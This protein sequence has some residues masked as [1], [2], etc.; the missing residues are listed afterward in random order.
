LNY[1]L[2][3]ELLRSLD[4]GFVGRLT[5][6]GR[7]GSLHLMVTSGEL[8]G[9]ESSEDD[10]LLLRRGVISGML[11][12]VQAG[13]MMRKV[14]QLPVADQLYDVL[15]EDIVAGL[16]F[17]RFKENI[18]SWLCA[19]SPIEHEA[20]PAIILTN[21]HLNHDS[22]A[23]VGEIELVLARTRALRRA[24]ALRTIV[25]HTG[26]KVEG[27][28]DKRL[29]S[30]VGGGRPLADIVRA[31]PFEELFTLDRVAQL[32]SDDV[33]AW[34]SQDTFIDDDVTEIHSPIPE[35]VAQATQAPPAPAHPPVEPTPA[36]L[37]SLRT[38]PPPP[39]DDEEGDDLSGVEDD[40]SELTLDPDLPSG[41]EL[42]L[43]PELE[44]E[45]FS[46]ADLGVEP[47]LDSP[48][49]PA[50]LSVQGFYQGP[51]QDIADAELAMFSDQ[52]LT[53]GKNEYVN[54]SELNQ[55]DYIE[56][57]T[58]IPEDDSLEAGDAGDGDVH[59]G[60]ARVRFSGPMLSDADARQKIEALNHALRVLSLAF[61]VG[62]GMG[63]G[64]SRIQLLLDGSPNELGMLFQKLEANDDGSISAT[65]LLAHLYRRPP[66]EHR[67]LLNR[68]LNDLME[69]ALSVGSEEMGD[70]AMDDVY[71]AYAEFK[72]AGSL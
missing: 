4:E 47:S 38:I 44:P 20:M 6:T 42:P 59:V 18:G 37:H 21:V 31:S 55:E 69:R 63:Y 24:E 57:P 51:D 10:I 19:E 35:P 13:E 32:L 28:E 60:N 36:P 72:Q 54:S 27:D 45:T 64:R 67:S 29:L 30:V 66:T 9:S 53:R 2:R 43:E 70:D 15:G 41:P 52:D 7:G 12:R 25:R 71:N 56:I 40:L 61:D 33:L 34:V 48:A 11:S 62:M 23:L 50:P 46:P 17:D 49:V 14:E 3:D 68:A 58:A 1:F 39:L 5:V 16:L 65:E 8:I 22:R 26:L